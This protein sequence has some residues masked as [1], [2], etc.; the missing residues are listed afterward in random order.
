MCIR[1][2][3]LPEE[4]RAAFDGDWFL[5][6]DAVR[7]DDEGYIVHMGRQSVDIIKSG[8]YKI[9]A[10][11]IEEALLTHPAID[12]VAVIGVEDAEW[13]EKI[14][15]A[16]VPQWGTPEEVP[17]LDWCTDHLD[18]QLARYKHPRDVL[19]LSEIPRN[20]L[21]KVQKH[22]IASS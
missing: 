22:R 18:G 1:D 21:G 13:G 11:E 10:R 15:A 16:V 8:G 9:S 12:E 5:T 14:V 17:W 4:T 3:N 2:R 19:V 7:Q 6:G 20:A